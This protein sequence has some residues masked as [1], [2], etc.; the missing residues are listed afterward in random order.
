MLV[1]TLPAAFEMEEILYELREHAAGLNAGRWDYVF[2]AIKT[3]GT[4]GRDYLLPDRSAVTMTAPFLRAYT[5][6]LVATCHRRGAHAIGG[7]AAAV[8]DRTTLSAPPRRSPGSGPTRSGRPRTASTAPGS[9]TPAW[10][11]R[12]A[13]CSTR[14]WAAGRTRC[15]AAGRRSRSPPADLLDLA[16][17]P[18]EV[19]A[20]GLRTN[21]SVGLRYL[22]AWL[23]GRGAVALD[24]LMEDAAT[25]EISRAQVWQWVREAVVL[26]DGTTVTAELVERLLAEELR[27]A[28]A[29]AARRAPVR[30]GGRGAARRR[31]SPERL[32][33]FLTT[34]AYARHLVTLG[35]A[36]G[37]PRRR[38]TDL[39]GCAA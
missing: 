5:E 9:R 14:C 31:C 10:S 35:P 6:L 30:G 11:A 12:A 25:A 2:S 4:R 23:G 29:G 3:Y 28:T 21:V 17:T 33:A 27:A 18:G 20:A 19:T 24:G 36:G 13:R 22:A 16:S 38:R 32:P 26:D 8:P 37:G 1:E 39:T 7:M 34:T 15:C